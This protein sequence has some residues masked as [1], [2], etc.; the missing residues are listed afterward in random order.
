MATRLGNRAARLVYE[1]VLSRDRRSPGERLRDVLGLDAGELL[2]DMVRMYSLAPVPGVEPGEA[3]RMLEE[4]LDQVLRDPNVWAF[5]VA[6][7]EL[8]I[9][10][11]AG[12][13]PG[14]SREEFL[15]DSG[16]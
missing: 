9:H 8:D 2:S 14:I 12:T 5:L 1:A 6:A 15:G 11:T 7:R 16:G 4:M 13:L 10:G 3:G